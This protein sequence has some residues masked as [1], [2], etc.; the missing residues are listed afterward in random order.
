MKTSH[1][2]LPSMQTVVDRFSPSKSRHHHT[3]RTS[4]SV[5]QAHYPPASVENVEDEDNVSFLTHHVPRVNNDKSMLDV[6]LQGCSDDQSESILS[7]DPSIASSNLLVP[8]VVS[9][10]SKKS[11]D[12]QKRQRQ[13]ENQRQ[14]EAA[15][16]RNRQ[17]ER[18]SDGRL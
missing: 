5:S 16:K 4:P 2:T 18:Y 11:A 7:S 6:T 17:E 14:R 12:S 13:K 15:R 1:F 3:L 9:D 10:A 8:S